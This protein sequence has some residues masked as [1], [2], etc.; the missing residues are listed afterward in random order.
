MEAPESTTEFSDIVAT[1]QQP[2]QIY[3]H[4]HIPFGMDSW[5]ALYVFIGMTA[6]IARYQYDYNGHFLWLL[7]H[8]CQNLK[9]LFDPDTCSLSKK[10]KLPDGSEVKVNKP[11]IGFRECEKQTTEFPGAPDGTLPNMWKYERAY[12]RI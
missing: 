12:L 7:F 11:L 1:P 5:V 2:Q 3:Y 6:A 4:Y 9:F 10:K 8:T